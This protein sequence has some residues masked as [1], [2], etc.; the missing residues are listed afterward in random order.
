MII[1]QKGQE[2]EL[3]MNI[4][5]NSRI[6]FTGYT[7]TFTH[8]LS[9][10]AKSYNIVTSNPAQYNDNERYCEIILPLDLPGQDLN[11]EGQYTLEIFGNDT[12]LVF[13]GIVRLDG[14]TEN[15]SIIEYISDNEDNEQYIYIQDY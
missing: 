12:D 5:N 2:N 8:T 3:V 6:D 9:Q 1:L 15:N 4:N 7:L 11:Y 13:T 10:E 14:T